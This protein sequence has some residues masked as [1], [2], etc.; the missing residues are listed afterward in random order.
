MPQFSMLYLASVGDQ[1][2]VGQNDHGTKFKSAK[3]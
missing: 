3:E 2:K 1:Q